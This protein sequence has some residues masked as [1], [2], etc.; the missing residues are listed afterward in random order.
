MT[1][2]RF[3]L[4]VCLLPATGLTQPIAFGVKG[5]VPVS[6]DSQDYPLVTQNACLGNYAGGLVC[7]RNDFEA[8]PYAVGPTVEIFLPWKLAFEVDA[9]YRRYHQD[10][11]SGLV[12]PRGGNY[13]FG[14][15][16]GAEANAWLFPVLLKYTPVDR[17][18]SPFVTAGTTLRRLGPLTG[19]GFALDLFLR[20]YPQPFYR[21]GQFDAA[22]TAGGGVRWRLAFL[23][24]SPEIRFLHWT[25]SNYPPIQNQAMLMIGITFAA[26]KH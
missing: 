20:P 13:S 24:L 5:G 9:L 7:G 21:D 25:S 22:I 11:A 10:I 23:D 19:Q 4:I 12:V 17:K 8:K 16:S 6:P 15:R 2:A 3:W 26:R 18:F 1:K 14:M